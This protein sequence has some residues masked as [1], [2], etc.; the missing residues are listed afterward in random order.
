VNIEKVGIVIQG[1][2]YNDLCVDKIIESYSCVKDNCVI[3]TWS[4]E[5]IELL[6]KLEDA[7]FKLIKSEMPEFRGHHNCN[8]QTK[9]SI[10]GINYLEKKGYSHILRM[11][12]D[13]IPNNT[14]KFIDV[15]SKISE[16]KIVFLCWINGYNIHYFTDFFTFGPTEIIKKFWDVEQLISEDTS[17]MFTEQ[18]LCYKFTNLEYPSYNDI[19]DIFTFSVKELYNNNI[20]L[21]WIKPTRDWGEEVKRTMTKLYN[22]ILHDYIN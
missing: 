11:R 19:S 12:S 4:N 17:K 9:S 1:T 14:V 16:H 2:L 18:Y 5:S 20:E 22:E 8:L 7:G 10:N 13:L 3:S 6:N 15:L 21:N